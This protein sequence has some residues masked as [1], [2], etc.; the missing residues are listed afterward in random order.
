MKKDSYQGL[1]LKGCC[2]LYA[3]QFFVWSNSVLAAFLRTLSSCSTSGTELLILNKLFL[4]WS[5]LTKTDLGS[6]FGQPPNPAYLFFSLLFSLSFCKLLFG[7]VLES[8]HS[9]QVSGLKNSNDKNLLGG[10]KAHLV[11]I[12]FILCCLSGF[13]VLTLLQ[14]TLSPTTT[15]TIFFC[16]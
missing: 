5:Y 3:F 2:L 11:D 4:V 12:Y 8:C 7:H 9:N 16:F 15:T 14:F 13:P 1:H 10:P 6:Y